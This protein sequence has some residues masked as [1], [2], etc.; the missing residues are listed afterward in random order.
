LTQAR[1][2]ISINTQIIKDNWDTI[3]YVVASIKLKHVS[4]SSLLRRLNSYPRQH[5]V[6]KALKELGKVGRT[7]FLLHYMDDHFLRNR[8]NKQ[9]QKGES[10]HHFSRAVFHEDN[11]EIRLASKQEHLRIDACKCLIQNRIICLNYLY[12]A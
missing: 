8:I 11:G 10:A 12:L 2:Q 5:P 7:D 9:L 4:A 6:F 1:Y 3:L